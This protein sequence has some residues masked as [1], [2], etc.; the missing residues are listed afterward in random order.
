MADAEQ[1]LT[2]MRG[3]AG[4]S[5]SGESVVSSDGAR[6]E[7]SDIV[8]SAPVLLTHCTAGSPL[9]LGDGAYAVDLPADSSFTFA[10]GVSPA[11]RVEVQA[12]TVRKALLDGEHVVLVNAEIIGDVKI[13][14]GSPLALTVEGGLY[15]DRCRFNG[16]LTLFQVEF[17]APVRF[18]LTDISGHVTMT[19]VGF[20]YSLQ[21]VPI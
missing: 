2:Q 3:G 6:V 8:L 14:V 12:D 19:K 1:I 13:G 7:L 15:C 10:H 9:L 5:H 20:R 18:V 17:R 16:S 11:D 21:V 4:V